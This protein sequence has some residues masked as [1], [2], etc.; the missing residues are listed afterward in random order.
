[1]VGCAGV[2]GTAAA[3]PRDAAATTPGAKA[4]AP[5]LLEVVTEPPGATV[6]V[7]G[8]QQP[9]PTPTL[10]ELPAVPGDHHRL[11][12]RLAGH[13]PFDGDVVVRAGERLRYERPLEPMHASLR[14]ATEPAGAQVSLDGKPLGVSPLSLAGLPADGATHTLR[15][16]RD[17]F[18]PVDVPVQLGDGAAV[19]VE[20]ALEPEV[21]WGKLNLQVDPWAY[22][23]FDG[24][25]IAEAPVAG[26]KLPVGK[27]K[28][29]L[30]NP[31][32]HAEKTVT[33]DVPAK[34]VGSAAFSME[35]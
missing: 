29:K 18:L 34:G 9:E 1:V 10:V 27:Q 35:P 21:R 4:S 33:V 31:A 17:G 30:V 14:V 2:T 25:R 13:R 8:V 32:I 26:L 19:E 28:L 15:L 3:L 7:G 11:E 6:L 5:A 12:L 24:K 16:E 23:Y 20:R 22:V